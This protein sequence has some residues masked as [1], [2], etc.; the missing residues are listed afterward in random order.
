MNNLA[1]FRSAVGDSMVVKVG[2][3]FHQSFEPAAD[4]RLGQSTGRSIAS[5]RWPWLGPATYSMMTNV[6]PA[7]LLVL[8]SGQRW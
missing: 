1:G 8:R 3:P 6:S 7:S 5:R 2:N 4:F